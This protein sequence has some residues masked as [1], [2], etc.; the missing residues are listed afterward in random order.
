MSRSSPLFGSW[1]LAAGDVLALLLFVSVGQR[2]HDLV[3]PRFPLVG[4]LGMTALFAL[5]WLAAAWRLGALT[6]AEPRAALL[7]FLGR[8]LNAWLVA[9]PLGVLLRSLVLRRAVIPVS[10]LLAALA[11]GGLFLLAWRAAFWLAHG[12]AARQKQPRAT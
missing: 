7:S 10:F 5:P 6:R 3:N 8:A 11:F 4:A 2:D 9:A 1:L 12:Y